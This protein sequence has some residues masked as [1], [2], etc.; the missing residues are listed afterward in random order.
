MATP[1]T[2]S[3][4]CPLQFYLAI[5]LAL[6]MAYG[7]GDSSGNAPGPSAKLTGTITDRRSGAPIPGATIQTSAG[8]QAQSL[9]DGQYLLLHDAG[10]FDVTVQAPGYIAPPTARLTLLEGE[11]VQYDV[12]LI[13]EGQNLAP[14]APQLENPPD[15]AVSVQLPATLTTGPFEDADNAERHTATQWQLSTSIDFGDAD[16]VIDHKSD[17]QLTALSPQ[18]FLLPSTSYYWRARVFDIADAP[19]D[20][21]DVYRFETAADADADGIPDA[22]ELQAGLDPMDTADAGAKTGVEGRTYLQTYLLGFSPQGEP[23]L[24]EDADKGLLSGWIRDADTDA[25]VTAEVT[26]SGS[27]WG[28]PPAGGA[29]LLVFDAGCYTLELMAEGYRTE[30]LSDV[31]IDALQVTVQ[32]VELVPLAHRKRRKSG[33]TDFP[34]CFLFCSSP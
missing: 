18:L 15:G 16:L 8:L 17:A 33:G 24:P 9:S 11:I 31:C 34:P 28:Q 7:C 5:L 25:V 23:P 3:T 12:D 26:T 32:D 4:R 1:S 14:H 21:S 30:T 6:L 10:E 27:V 13:A 2:L 22:W 20:W 19:S 29:Y